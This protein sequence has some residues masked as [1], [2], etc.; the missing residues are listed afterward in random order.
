MELSEQDIDLAALLQSCLR[1]VRQKAKDVSVDLVEAIPEGLPAVRA[2]EL[3]IKQ[4]VLNLLSNALKF[5][6]AGGTVTIAVTPAEGGTI[7][8]TIKDTGIGMSEEDI[9]I[10]LQPFRQVD[11][12]LV[13]RQEGTGLGLPLVNALVDLHGGTLTITSEPGDG[14]LVTVALPPERVVTTPNADNIVRFAAAAR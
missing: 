8:L 7:A 3:R 9:A 5:T 4:I 14:T 13:R 11:N 1:I 12:A 10:A 2:D 6:P